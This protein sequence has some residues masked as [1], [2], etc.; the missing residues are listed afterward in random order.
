M[1]WDKAFEELANETSNRNDAVSQDKL[2]AKSKAEHD[3]G[4]RNGWHD[5]YGNSLLADEDDDGDDA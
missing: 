3:R 4:V 5:E 1:D 2:D